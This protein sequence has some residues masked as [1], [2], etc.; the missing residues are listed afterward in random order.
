MK[1]IMDE[2]QTT[3]QQTEQQQPSPVEQLEALRAS[4]VSKE[5]YERVVKERNQIFA[6]LAQQKSLPNAG[7][8]EPTTEQ[9]AERRE[10]LRKELYSENC[11]LS[12]LDYWKKT[13]E[14]RKLIMDD[15]GKDPFLPWGKDNAVDDDDYKIVQRVVDGVQSC[16]DY[17]DGDSDIFTTELQRITVDTPVAR[18][19]NAARKGR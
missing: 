2:K 18:M 15:G 7:T 17:A 19:T 12:N 11:N 14:L 10:A 4:T 8:E 3:T 1:I 13:L 5:E 16:I 6:T 9:R